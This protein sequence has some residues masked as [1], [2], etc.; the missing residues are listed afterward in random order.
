MRSLLTSRQQ[1]LRATVTV[2]HDRSKLPSR[3]FRP[4]WSPNIRSLILYI[5]DGLRAARFKWYPACTSLS[6]CSSILLDE[7]LLS[8]R[9]IRFESGQSGTLDNTSERV[10][11]R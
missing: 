6:G 2:G 8:A 10:Q 11:A 3:V 5:E 4:L 9:A 7:V 1:V